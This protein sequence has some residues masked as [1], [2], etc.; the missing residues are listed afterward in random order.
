MLWSGEATRVVT[1][2]T[3]AVQVPPLYRHLPKREDVESHLSGNLWLRTFSY[4]REVECATRRDELEGIGSGPLPD[5]MHLT[6]CGE[7]YPINPTFILCFTEIKS[8]D[9]FGLHSIRLLDGEKLQE[10]IKRRLCLIKFVSTSLLPVTYADAPYIAMPTPAELTDR[11]ELTK[12]TRFEHE[13]EW[14]LIL[15][16]PPCGI[17]NDTLKLHVGDLDD[18]IDLPPP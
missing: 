6:V 12:P 14:R 10:R 3:G 7:D 8:T 17:R 4:F 18:V 5:G 9:A 1:N 16:L 2:A 11:M 13:R 15:R